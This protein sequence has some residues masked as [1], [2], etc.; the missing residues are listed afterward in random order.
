MAKKPSTPKSDV[1]RPENNISSQQ[2]IIDRLVKKG[3]KIF[4]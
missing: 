3:V 2:K 1:P 4:Y